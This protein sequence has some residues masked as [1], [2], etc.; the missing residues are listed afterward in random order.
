MGRRRREGQEEQSI[1]LRWI[2]TSWT[3]TSL[4]TILRRSINLSGR[5]VDLGAMNI[6]DCTLDRSILV[7]RD[8]LLVGNRLGKYDY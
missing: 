3:T 1:L 7:R 6:S 4:A 5:R 8:I 2:V